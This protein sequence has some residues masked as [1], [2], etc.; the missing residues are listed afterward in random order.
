[1]LARKQLLQGPHKLN[2]RPHRRLLGRTT[3]RIDVKFDYIFAEE[4]TPDLIGVNRKLSFEACTRAVTPNA[5]PL[6]GPTSVN[7]I[8]VAEDAFVAHRSRLSIEPLI[9]SINDFEL[10]FLAFCAPVDELT[11]SNSTWTMRQV[12]GQILF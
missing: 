9:A 12:T 3:I 1:M 7:H 11:G 10:Q 8:H 4:H 6:S 2:A 5:A